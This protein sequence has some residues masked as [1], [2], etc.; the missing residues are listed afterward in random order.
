MVGVEP[1]TYGLQNTCDKSIRDVSA[2]SCAD[3]GEALGRALGQLTPSDPDL[4]AIVKAWPAL[5]AALKAGI[6]AMVKASG[7]EQ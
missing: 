7:G 2:D 5:P 4:A 3:K 6:L 1:A